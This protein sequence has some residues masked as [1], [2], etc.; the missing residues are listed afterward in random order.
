MGAHLAPL[1]LTQ[2]ERAS[3]FPTRGE[4]VKFLSDSQL[5]IQRAEAFEALVKEARCMLLN[6]RS[7][8]GTHRCSLR[9]PRLQLPG[10]AGNEPGS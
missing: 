1:E 7:E 4:G 10:R 5:L 2:P 3:G 8:R 6:E 9:M